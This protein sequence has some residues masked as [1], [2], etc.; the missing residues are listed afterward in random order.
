MQ[1][2]FYFILLSFVLLSFSAFNARIAEGWVFWGSSSLL[3]CRFLLCSLKMSV[4]QWHRKRFKCTKGRLTYPLSN[5][6]K[7]TKRASNQQ[8]NRQKRCSFELLECCSHWKRSNFKAIVLYTGIS[9]TS[10][11]VS[12]M[13][14]WVRCVSAHLYNSRGP[15]NNI[16][17]KIKNSF[18]QI[19][20][21]S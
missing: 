17:G 10:N 20:S 18:T 8:Q 2:A 13:G 5:K 11:L 9:C 14:L 1:R 16:S 7:Q 6:R 3:V 12:C 19:F 21:V 4:Q 15:V